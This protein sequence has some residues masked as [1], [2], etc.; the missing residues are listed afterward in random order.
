MVVKQLPIGWQMSEFDSVRGLALL[1]DQQEYEKQ[2]GETDQAQQWVNKI[3]RTAALRNGVDNS[4]AQQTEGKEHA[5]AC[6][7]DQKSRS[8]DEC[9]YDIEP[10]MAYSV[11]HSVVQ[12]ESGERHANE[13]LVVHTEKRKAQNV[14]VGHHD[15]IVV[16]LDKIEDGSFVDG[17][18]QRETKEH[19]Q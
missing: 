13:R 11:Q 19:E 14:T 8:D 9:Q 10:T 5:G 15:E 16:G 12:E 1:C 3:L 7:T 17:T 2:K 18:L 4:N 6:A